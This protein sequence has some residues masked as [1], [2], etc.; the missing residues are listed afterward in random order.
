M[1]KPR[2][3]IERAER[4]RVA[5]LADKE[6]LKAVCGG[7]T[8]AETQWIER[9]LPVLFRYI[10]LGFNDHYR[11]S[12]MAEQIMAEYL[13][14]VRQGNISPDDTRTVF[15]LADI[16]IVQPVQRGTGLGLSS[17]QAALLE[18]MSRLP[19]DQRIVFDMSV[20]GE[21]GD[22][23]IKLRMGV[24]SG[25][26]QK[27]RDTVTE[28]VAEMPMKERVEHARQ[29]HRKIG[30]GQK[31]D[32]FSKFRD[33]SPA[34]S[35]SRSTD[36]PSSRPSDRQSRSPGRSPERRWEEKPARHGGRPSTRSSTGPSD[37]QQ[38]PPG[39][40]PE[41]R[42]EE[43]PARHER[44]ST[45]SSTGSSD[46][47]QRPPGRSPERRWEEKRPP[48][49]QWRKPDPSA[50]SRR[51]RPRPAAGPTDRE[52]GSSQ[53]TPEYRSRSVRPQEKRPPRKDN[54]DDK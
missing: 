41:R 26:I 19:R 39:R 13:Q 49:K 42:W 16:R 50:I 10:R 4:D 21:T 33:R 30:S 17:K 28:M 24:D 9:Y 35:S 15:D 2:E 52:T 14:G 20:L 29:I 32:R 8:A 44:P 27:I 5:V 23:D 37:R 38:R 54:G 11:T 7:D 1:E 12:D 18:L 34:R 51:K 48:G 53:E 31:T 40:S 47:Q 46:R 45:R 36:R 6:L 43:R 25:M 3:N 22:E